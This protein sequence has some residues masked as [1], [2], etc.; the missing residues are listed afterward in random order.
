MAITPVETTTIIKHAAKLLN[1]A[2][3][4]KL[5]NFAQN[6][7]FFFLSER[8]SMNPHHRQQKIKAFR[9][10]ASSA[11]QSVVTWETGF[12]TQPALDKWQA[13]TANSNY[14]KTTSRST[15]LDRLLAP[16]KPNLIDTC[17]IIVIITCNRCNNHVHIMP[18]SNLMKLSTT[19]TGQVGCYH[20]T[21]TLLDIYRLPICSIN[22]IASFRSKTAEPIFHGENTRH[23]GKIPRELHSKLCQCLISLMRQI[24]LK[25]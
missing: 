22:I 4:A 24:G 3:A 15:F 21:D 19:E 7:A 11:T 20:M 13:A 18:N 10:S 12:T 25:P 6:A 8:V 23:A 2:Q 17:N 5:L 16:A 14:Y 9:V 1:F